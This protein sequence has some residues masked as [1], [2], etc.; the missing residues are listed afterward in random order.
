MAEFREYSKKDFLETTE[1]FEILYQYKDNEFVL[2]Q[3]VEQMAEMAANAGVKG[4]KTLFKNYC[5]AKK[6]AETGQYIANATNFDRQPLE[7]DCGEWIANDS[8]IWA[9][10][11]LGPELA[12]IHP[13]MPVMRL[14]NIDTNTEKLQLAYRRGGIWKKTIADKRT[15]AAASS[16]ISLADVGVAVN[17]ENAKQLVRFLHDAENLNYD[18]IEEKKSVGRLGWVE[19]YGFSPYVEN[20]VFDGDAACKGLFESVKEVGSF[21]TWLQL[22]KGIRQESI[23]G[24][25]LMA[26]SFASVLV[27]PLNCLPFFLHLWGGTEAGKTVGE[28]LAASL[29]ADPRVGRY[30]Q[31]FNSTFVGKERAAAFVGNLPLIMDELQIANGQGSFDKDIYMLSEGVGRTRG[32]KVG[33]VDTTATWAN[34]IITNGEM[35]L[36]ST[37][38][39]GGAVNRIIEIECEEALF[40]DPKHV[41]DTLLENYGYAGKMG[42]DW[43]ME[44]DP[45]FVTVR[46][47]YRIYM[48][49]FDKKDTTGKQSM[50]MSLILVGDFVLTNAVF[51]DDLA[52]KPED[53][54][55]FLKTK[56]EVSVHERAYEYI[57]QTLVANKHRFGETE[58]DR[59]EVWGATDE[60]YFYVIRNYFEQICKDGGF[61]SKALLSWMKRTG[62]IEVSKKG[63]TKMKRVN[64]EPIHCVWIIKPK[65][66][67]D[68]FEQVGL[69]DKEGNACPF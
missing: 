15:L 23:Y 63:N 65:D 58:N 12:C 47:L 52:L 11:Y 36:A 35:P 2:M 18:R 32:N 5:K 26:A 55:K 21:E 41:A 17:S 45:E 29:W 16:I 31:T 38:S 59:N 68:G 8:G 39:G 66:E 19:G 53:V 62:K 43:L 25:I 54:Q 48:Q 4:F 60:N 22:A 27:K 9:N 37:A 14:V 44:Y 40:A 46:Q 42:L 28:M 33:G 10:G 50:A 51:H 61:N 64:G 6:K 56:Q 57:Y 1:P 34:C 49:E 24:R 30:I 13:I 69:M 67:N 20:L 7:L 3:M